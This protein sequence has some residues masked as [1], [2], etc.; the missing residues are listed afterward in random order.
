MTTTDRRQF[1]TL[2]AATT[3]WAA[4]SPALARA[5]A[6]AGGTFTPLRAGTGYF[7]AQGGTIGWAAGKKAVLV[8]DSQFPDTAES[9]LRGIGK[10]A[11]APVTTLVNTH[12]HRDHTSGN[13]VF[14]PVV[15]HIVAQEKVPEL[16]RRFA[17]EDSG[18]PVVADVTFDARWTTDLGGRKVT[19]VKRAPAHTGG[20]ASVHIEEADVVHVGDLIFNRLY[21]FID[22]DGGASI[23]GW[24]T[25]LEKMAAEYG[26]E[27]RF[28]FG[29]GAP[30]FGVTGD[31]SDLLV[32]R[33]FFVALLEHV[34]RS[35]SA[36]ASR[37]E[38]IS[39]EQLKG[40]PDHQPRGSF[41]ILENCLGAA[42][43]ELHPNES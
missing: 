13:G 32:Q 5:A 30:G 15:Q 8:I 17:S 9:F 36:G 23:R 25:S 31:R 41:L 39:L 7:T 20:D 27:T 19:A 22:I 40:F 26:A 4:T 6:A 38:T 12:H 35:M 37:Q 33:D 42:W 43:R 2:M 34:G 24:I 29:H 10:H 21:P 3:A 16:Q 1:L 11:A 14:R 18:P 28:I